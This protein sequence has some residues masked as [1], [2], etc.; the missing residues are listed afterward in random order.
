MMCTHTRTHA[1]TDTR[2]HTHTHT[3]THAHIHRHNA[4]TCAYIHTRTRIH[5]YTQHKQPARDRRQAASEPV[6]ES[7]TKS[8]TESVCGFMWAGQTG[9]PRGRQGGLARTHRR[10]KREVREGTISTITSI[11]SRRKRG[12]GSRCDKP[13]TRTAR[14][15][16]ILVRKNALSTNI[17]QQWR[18]LQ[19]CTQD[20]EQKNITPSAVLVACIPTGTGSYVRYVP[21]PL[22]QVLRSPRIR[23]AEHE[24]RVRAI[25]QIGKILIKNL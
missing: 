15:N 16:T 23:F 1:H 6:S 9:G 12:S 3:H 11:S 21:R 22:L 18:R 17:L 10:A 7:V 13:V 19:S 2:T 25:L 14:R 20:A 5:T 24:M 4:Y 8:V